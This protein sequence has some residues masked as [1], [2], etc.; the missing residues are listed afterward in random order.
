MGSRSLMAR[1]T[2]KKALLSPCGHKNV[3]K[4]MSIRELPLKL[5]EGAWPWHAVLWELLLSM[6]RVGCFLKARGGT[7]SGFLCV[8]P[9]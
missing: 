6:A 4:Q 8:T 3:L 1:L 5:S 2:D 9:G 7:T